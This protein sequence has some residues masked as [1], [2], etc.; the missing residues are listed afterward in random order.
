MVTLE[1]E[2]KIYSIALCVL[3]WYLRFYYY[4]W[5]DTSAYGLLVPEATIR[6]LL[7]PEAIIRPLLVPEAIIRPLLIPEAI[8]RPLL[9]PEAIIRPVVRA[10]A[11][12]WFIRYIYYWNL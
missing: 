1:V 11:L 7:V 12:T 6:P 9:V 3:N 10:T 5:V 2:N 8:I 4:D